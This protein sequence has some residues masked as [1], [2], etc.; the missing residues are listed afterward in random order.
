M[1][2]VLVPFAEQTEDM[3]M[4]ILTDIL[5]RAGATVIRAASSL[6]PVKLQ[7]G[8]TIIPDTTYLAVRDE[9]FD[10][11]A[12]PGG[13]KGVERMDSDPDIAYI[14]KRCKSKS[15]Y[16]A[17]VCSAPNLLRRHSIIEN[18]IKFTVHPASLDFASGGLAKTDATFVKSKS[19]ITGRSAGHTLDWALEIVK[20][21][22]GPDRKDEVYKSLGIIS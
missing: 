10:I 8:T 18:D 16:I 4:V 14:L 12:I 19:V 6:N 1:K 22:F 2:R 13:W 17:A 15:S 20:E 5:S 21:L 11:V 7:Y 3:E 9:D